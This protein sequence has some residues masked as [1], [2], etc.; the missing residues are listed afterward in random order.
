VYDNTVLFPQPTK[1]RLYSGFVLPILLY[2][3]E[4]WTFTKEPSKTFDVFDMKS[5]RCLEELGW[6]DYE[7]KEE[8]CR[9]TASLIFKNEAPTLRTPCQAGTDT[10]KAADHLTKGPQ[11]GG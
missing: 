6:V 8:L 2:A 11:D 5:L 4:T 3:S 10:G 7:R 9:R 1:L